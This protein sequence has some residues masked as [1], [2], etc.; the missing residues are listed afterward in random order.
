MTATR[1]QRIADLTPERRQLLDALLR[2]KANVPAASPAPTQRAA[3]AQAGAASTAIAAAA[4]AAVS[5]PPEAPS[6]DLL[7]GEKAKTKRF[8]DAVNAQLDPTPFGAFSFFLN[9]GYVSDG[10]TPDS[11]VV[12]LPEQAMNRHSVKLVLETIGDCPLDGRDVLDV[13]CGRGGTVVTL[14]TFFTPALIAAMD[15]STRAVQFCHTT[16]TGTHA[17]FLEADAEHIPFADGR[18][19]VVTNIE[20]SHLYPD[21]DAFYGEVFR[22]LRPGGRFQ[23]ADLQPA[24]RW[25]DRVRA[26]RA[27]GFAI[28][29]ERDIT[30]NVL[31][32]CDQLA[33]QRV[34]AYQ[35]PQ[36]VETLQEFLGAPGSQVYNDLARRAWVYHV[37]T[38]VKP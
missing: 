13:G 7:T 4:E 34:Q 33:R 18:F 36:Q 25:R 14:R 1:A 30:N 15:L 21:V 26:L 29:R 2:S 22:V 19:D 3:S 35:S 16:H 20:S 32:S 9:Y 17:R 27:L 12:S 28:S 38:A 6:L 23:Y 5:A 24:D 8:Y 10:L 37:V 11:A 31:L